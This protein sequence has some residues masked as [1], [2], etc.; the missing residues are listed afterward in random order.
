MSFPTRRRLDRAGL[1][2]TPWAFISPLPELRTLTCTPQPGAFV[3]CCK[4]TERDPSS[5]PSSSPKQSPRGQ[6]GSRNVRSLRPPCVLRPVPSRELPEHSFSSTFCGPQ[7]ALGHTKK[8]VARCSKAMA[9][10]GPSP[11]FTCK[12]VGESWGPPQKQNGWVPQVVLS[13]GTS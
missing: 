12:G 8:H 3:L 1:N 6:K 5:V 10:S 7:G 2:G 4:S 13:P 11:F 9:S